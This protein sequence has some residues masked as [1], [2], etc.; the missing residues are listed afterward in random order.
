MMILIKYLPDECASSPCQNNAICVQKNN[1]TFECQCAGT[2]F[3]GSFCEID[4]NECEI[5]QI[6]C[7]GKGTCINTLGSFR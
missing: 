2:G 6:N 7:G 5:E 1:G 3:M 4:I